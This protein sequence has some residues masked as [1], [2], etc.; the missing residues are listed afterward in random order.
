MNG[1]TSLWR[2]FPSDRLVSGDL[3]GKFIRHD[4]HGDDDNYA[5]DCV[6]GRNFF[7]APHKDYIV[8]FKAVGKTPL[9]QL[10]QWR[11]IAHLQTEDTSGYQYIYPYADET[12][13][14]IGASQSWSSLRDGVGT[15]LDSDKTQVYS[16]LV[17]SS[18]SQEFTE[19][20]RAALIYD[21]SSIP[22]DA[23]F[24]RI[25][26]AFYT[27]DKST[28]LGAYD[29]GITMFYPATAG[30]IVYG[31]FNTFGET[32]LSK[33]YGYIASSGLDISTWDGFYLHT[34]PAYGTVINTTGY[35][36]L[37]L[38]Y[39]WDMENTAPPWVS[40]AEDIFA[41][42]S[43][44]GGN[45]P[46]L[47][48]NWHRPFEDTEPFV[49]GE[50]YHYKAARVQN[51]LVSFESRIAHH[52]YGGYVAECLTND[53]VIDSSSTN[54]TTLRNAGGNELYSPPTEIGT[55]QFTNA[56][57]QDS[58]AYLQR[59]IIAFDTAGLP[60][61]AIIT[62]GFV[63]FFGYWKSNPQ[64]NRLALNAANGGEDGTILPWYARKSSETV[65]SD[66]AQYWQGS[67]S[68]KVVTP[69]TYTYEGIECN[70]Y[71]IGDIAPSNNYTF[72]IYLRGSGTVQL[73]LSEYDANRDWV[74]ATGSSTITL[75]ASWVRYSV[76]HSFGSTGVHAVVLVQT[77]TQQ[78]ATF[79]ADGAQL[80][81]GSSPTTFSLP[82][83]NP[84]LDLSTVDSTPSVPVVAGDYNNTTFTR[85]ADDI[86]YANF[87][88][89]EWNFT[90]LTTYGKSHILKTE[91]TS[92]MLTSK[93]EADNSATVWV[94]NAEYQI[95][96]RGLFPLSYNDALESELPPYIAV[97]YTVPTLQTISANLTF[98]SVLNAVKQG[99][100]QFYQGVSSSLVFT[101]SIAKALTMG[102]TIPANATFTSTITNIATRLRSL[103][104][105]STFSVSILKALS[106]N[107]NISANA[108]FTP[109]VTKIATR[110]RTLSVNA[111][112]SVSISRL[113]TFYRTISASLASTVS[114]NSLKSRFV[115][116]S[117]SL[118]STVTLV[119]GLSLNRSMSVT[120]GATVTLS[121]TSTLYRTL[122]SPATFVVSIT[123]GMYRTLSANAAFT[124]AL[125]AIKQAQTFYRTLSADAAFSVST[126]RQ[127][128]LNRSLSS[129]ATFTVAISKLT[130][131]Y[132]SFA[133]NSTFTVGVVKSLTMYRVLSV[134][135]N[136]TVSLSRTLSMKR[137]LSVTEE[138][139]PILSR[140]SQLKRA[141]SAAVSF[142]ASLVSSK[143]APYP[144]DQLPTVYLTCD[145]NNGISLSCDTTPSVSLEC[146]STTKT[147][148]LICRET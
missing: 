38:R 78:A 115:T 84:T 21:T 129:N 9:G 94:P 81:C 101:V 90:D 146:D 65:T 137:T 121:R 92:L 82:G 136:A 117:A 49:F 45:Q 120:E 125:G 80:E 97:W 148:Y 99:G 147:I 105:N 135:E 89:Q 29:L 118:A 96:S 30:S 79:W 75:T 60:D 36:N 104:A 123:R 42:S 107:R 34:D 106:L 32:N 67:R 138:P 141:F 76:T 18:T 55:G 68:I 69:S 86:S 11:E 51:N 17:A 139:V 134:V 111:T 109:S 54:W 128:T 93:A 73:E 44:S 47:E 133:T 77:A 131:R 43:M 22:D 14:R 26:F 91:A 8:L 142:I 132:R 98:T 37:M 127:N 114:L 52:A 58:W 116:I 108:T 57:T 4:V 23:I 83:S 119:R 27:T 144:P 66:T 19:L 6:A 100:Q 5:L 20:C 74:A 70:T 15:N 25:L 48:L 50:M 72:S 24:D 126:S 130:T 122:S 102:R 28:A 62:S 56:T 10:T 87:T 143:K 12:I 7:L 1:L 71:S 13:S 103:S 145:T 88:D 40:A 16:H 59:T 31:D 61:T 35:T 53:S 63:G 2:S 41:A 124:I 39:S 85:M 33:Y 110:V 112:F 46:Y 113:L 95:L 3:L 140:T 64:L